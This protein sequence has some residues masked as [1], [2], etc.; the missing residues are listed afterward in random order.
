V[1][2][3]LRILHI[4]Y[5]MTR[6]GC[7]HNIMMDN[8]SIQAVHRAIIICFAHELRQ[9]QVLWELDILADLTKNTRLF[10]EKGFA[11]NVNT[12][13]LYAYINLFQTQHRK[14]YTKTNLLIANGILE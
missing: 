4:T 11:L 6:D 3:P 12:I 2:L 8:H 14:I 7:I 10:K 13:L 5:I 1:P 9:I